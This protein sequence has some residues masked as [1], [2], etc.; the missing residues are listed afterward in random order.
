MGWRATHTQ[1]VWPLVTVTLPFTRTAPAQAGA[2]A[3]LDQ[4]PESRRRAQLAVAER[5]RLTAGLRRPE[6]GLASSF[7]NFVWLP[8]GHGSPEYA[9]AC[10]EAEWSVRRIAGEGVRV[11]VGLAEG[12]Q[13]VLEVASIYCSGQARLC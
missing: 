8:H 12:N 7:A 1:V 10:P 4:E 2:L 13:A 3:A 11:M 9:A 5:E 6:L